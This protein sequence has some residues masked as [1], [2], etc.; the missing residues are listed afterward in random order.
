MSSCAAGARIEREAAAERL[1]AG[2]VE[3]LEASS[4]DFAEAVRE[5]ASAAD[6]SLV[7]HDHGT[8]PFAGMSSEDQEHLRDRAL[9]KT[10]RPEQGAA[11]RPR[12]GGL[13]RGHRV[14]R[15]SAP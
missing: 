4:R 3:Y 8:G 9:V 1:R 14:L 6:I 13:F 10:N 5:D 2:L 15:E 11:V 12:E 7:L